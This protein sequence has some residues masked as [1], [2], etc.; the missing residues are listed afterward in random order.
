MDDSGFLAFQF[1]NG[2]IKRADF[3]AKHKRFHMFQF[4]NGAIKRK[5]QQF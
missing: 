3:E 5:K 1:Q 2:A 4:Q